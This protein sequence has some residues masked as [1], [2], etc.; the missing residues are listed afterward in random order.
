MK[1]NESI[2]NTKQNKIFLDA[3]IIGGAVMAVLS[4]IPIINL[5]NV[6]CCMWL[7]AG[8]VVSY[9]YASKKEGYVSRSTDGLLYG[10]LSGIFGWIMNVVLGFLML[11]IRV[12]KFNLIKEK[13]SQIAGPEADKIIQIINNFGVFGFF[14]TVNLVFIIFYLIFPSIGGAVAQSLTKKKE[15]KPE[16][17]VD[18]NELQD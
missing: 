13:L 8:G 12:E 1:Q 18:H 14:L 10:V 4:L 5:F 6:F 7:I 11:S 16:V 2:G 9:I 15:V 3:P 17:S